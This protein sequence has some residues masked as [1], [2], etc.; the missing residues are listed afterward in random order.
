MGDTS[1]APPLL[2]QI[3]VG[4][5]SI[6]ANGAHDGATTYDTVSLCTDGMPVIIPL[7]ATAVLS[8]AADHH[9]SRS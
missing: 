4:I 2:D 8:V 3:A 1:Q 7:H 9:P 6:T 5:G